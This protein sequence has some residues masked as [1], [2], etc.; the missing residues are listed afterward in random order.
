MLLPRSW[1]AGLRLQFW[2]TLIGLLSLLSQEGAADESDN[3]QETTVLP[4]NDF[5][6]TVSTWKGTTKETPRNTNPSPSPSLGP[7]LG[8]SSS[9]SPSFTSLKS[10]PAPGSTQSTTPNPETSEPET[11]SPISTSGVSLTSGAVNTSAQNEI[12]PATMVPTNLTTANS[13]SPEATVTTSM[14]ETTS[15]PLSNGTNTTTISTAPLLTSMVPVIIE[16]HIKC[17]KIKQ[18]QALKGICLELNETYSCEDFKKAQGDNLTKV[19]CEPKVSE[20]E[21]GTQDCSLILAQSEVNPS[22][23]FLVLDS[24]DITHMLEVMN[25]HKSNLEKLGI[26]DFQEQDIRSH[27][28]YSRKTLIALVTS[29]LLLA[30]LGTAG[31]FLMNRR[32]WSPAGE[33]LGEDPYYTENGGGQGYGAG[34][35]AS[36]DSQEKASQN[37]GAQENGTSQ[38]T[39]SNGHS[40]RQHVVADTE[41]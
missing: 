16:K 30:A 13:S 14:S 35:G 39:S 36:P 32:S 34:P 10:S 24:K 4:E 5:N 21:A 11:Q 6:L 27:Q 29:G 37:R 23:L 20:A 17:L 2:A 41:L 19:V 31:Y 38:A 7:S 15:S 22:C 1:R 25:K 12:L 33:R 28:S 40:S 26:Q 18:V 9:P 8:P 3:L